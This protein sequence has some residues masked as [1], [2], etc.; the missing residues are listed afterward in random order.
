ME[1]NDKLFLSGKGFKSIRNMYLFPSLRLLYF[2][3]NGKSQIYE[4][5]LLLLL[6]PI[7]CD[8]MLGLQQN[9]DLRNLYLHENLITKI[10]GLENLRELR[11]INLSKNLISQISGLENCAKLDSILIVGN[12]LGQDEEI[13]DV[14]ALKGLLD[15]PTLEILDITDNYISD[16]AV[17]PE[18]FEKLP[19]LRLLRCKGNKFRDSIS[20]YRKTIIARLPNL[21]YLDDRKVTYEDRRRAEAFAIG[22]KEAEQKEI[23]MLKVEK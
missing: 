6:C 12:R 3:G 8:S 22:K 13:S 18:I 15:A 17:L 1:I 16:P 9:P 5:F 2:H 10:E 7:G 20:D 14:E 11:Q 4:Y 19:N 23:E 21:H